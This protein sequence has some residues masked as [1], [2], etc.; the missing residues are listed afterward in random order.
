MN[1]LVVGFQVKILVGL[2]LLVALWPVIL[3]L[4]ERLYGLAFTRLGEILVVL[5]GLG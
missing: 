2:L 1:V 4:A 3:R 5:G